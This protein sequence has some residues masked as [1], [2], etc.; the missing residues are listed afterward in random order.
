MTDKV[1]EH[2][3]AVYYDSFGNGYITQEVLNKRKDKCIT[4]DILE[5]K[6]MIHLCMDFIVSLSYNNWLQEKFC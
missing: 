4:G 2:I 5:Y 3:T 1:K 6:I